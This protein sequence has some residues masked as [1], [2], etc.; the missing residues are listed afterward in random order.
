MICLYELWVRTDVQYISCH[1]TLNVITSSCTLDYDVSLSVRLR[2]S[3]S[4]NETQHVHTLSISIYFTPLVKGSSAWRTGLSRFIFRLLQDICDWSV[5]PTPFSR[6]PNT[7]SLPPPIVCKSGRDWAS[8]WGWGWWLL[9]RW[10]TQ[11][12][13]RQPR[14]EIAAP[15]ELS[16]APR[17]W[18]SS[19]SVR[20]WC[21]LT[22][23]WDG[24]NGFHSLSAANFSRGHLSVPH[25]AS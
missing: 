19:P 24:I 10:R 5:P 21:T 11:R 20:S 25:I 23:F 3:A 17:C 2:K 12:P 4:I 8:R 16:T 22:I 6:P 1:L 14:G 13:E 15:S 9:S 7:P 18:T